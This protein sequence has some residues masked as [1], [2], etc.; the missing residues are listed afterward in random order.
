MGTT[1][2]LKHRKICLALAIASIII[3]FLIFFPT[4]QPLGKYNSIPELDGK[5][6]SAIHLLPSEPDWKVNLVGKNF[7]IAN[8]QQIDT[9]TRLLRTTSLYTPSHPI[10][11]WET[12]MKFITTSDD[13]FELTINKNN[14]DYNGTV[15]Q[16]P[17]N[18]YRMDEIA[19][20]LEKVT[21]YRQPVYGDSTKANP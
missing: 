1:K 11:I 7:K 21:N 13:T 10:R 19:G 20:Y 9:I 8:K 12:K 17:F 18:N 4:G 15:I 2:Y 5:T 14:N 3:F 16:T 6:I